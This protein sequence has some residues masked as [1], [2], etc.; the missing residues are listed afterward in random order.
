MHNEQ[1]AA[2]N[3]TLTEHTPLQVDDR[4]PVPDPVPVPQQEPLASQEE[5]VT[6]TTE[7]AVSPSEP[8]VPSDQPTVPAAEEK[9]EESVPAHPQPAQTETA[10]NAS[11][12]V[13]EPTLTPTPS[14]ESAPAP[15]E[16]EAA[17]DKN[18]APEDSDED[19]YSIRNFSL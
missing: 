19:L 15:T 14:P 11:E 9:K 13:A 1:A 10:H 16:D 2:V 12:P 5:V 8:T 17:S 3:D 6:D 18:A 4:Q 7:E